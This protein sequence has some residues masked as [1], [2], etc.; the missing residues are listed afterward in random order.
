MVEIKAKY[1]IG[2]RRF[3]N[4]NWIGAWTLYKKVLRFLIVWIQTIFFSARHI[5]FVF[6][7]FVFS[8]R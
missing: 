1:K 6:T 2:T 3:G 5:P 4:I 7:G 8:N